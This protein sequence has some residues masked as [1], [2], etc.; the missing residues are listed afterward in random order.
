MM[1]SESSIES[2]ISEESDYSVFEDESEKNLFVSRI[3]GIVISETLFA[4][5]MATGLNMKVCF[6]VLYVLLLCYH[7]IRNYYP[8]NKILLA[9]L[10]ITVGFLGGGLWA[11]ERRYII[12]YSLAAD[13]ILIL[14]ITLLVKFEKIFFLRFGGIVT[15]GY[16]LLSLYAIFIGYWQM[17]YQFYYLIVSFAML[18]FIL[19]LMLY[20][21]LS[22]CIIGKNTENLN[23][24][25]RM[26]DTADGACIVISQFMFVSICLSLL[27]CN[28]VMSFLLET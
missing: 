21:Y 12:L 3:Y 28:T 18:S 8:I 19:S 27:N 24:I 13:I 23:W 7:R 20:G 22:S 25:L 11:N 4:A 10:P 1:K 17:F 6:L 16:Y 15:I 14:L 5:A 9:V 26:N 2:D